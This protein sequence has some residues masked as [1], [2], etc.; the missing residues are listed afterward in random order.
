M[1]YKKP[2]V[3]IIML[4]LMI[5]CFDLA[6][7]YRNYARPE[8]E[9]ANIYIKNSSLT[10]TD[11]TNMHKEE[12]KETDKL[13]FTGWKQLDDES[14]SYPY[15]E[16]S[17]TVDILKVCGNSSLIVDAPMIFLG[18]TESCILDEDTAYSLFGSLEVSGQKITYNERELTVIA[19][20]NKLKDTII[21]HTENDS[22]ENMDAIAL[23]LN[24]EGARTI[25]KF[26]NRYAVSTNTTSTAVYSEVVESNIYYNIANIFTLIIP[27]SIIILLLFNF[28]KVVKKS[29]RKPILFLVYTIVGC[30][31]IGMFIALME[32]KPSIPYDLIPNKWSDFDYWTTL[33]KGYKEKYETILYMKKYNMDIV[34]IQSMFKSIVCSIISIILFF[35]VRKRFKINNYDNLFIFLFAIIIFE[36]IAVLIVRMKFGLQIS[37]LRAWLLIPYYYLGMY[38]ISFALKIRDKDI[39]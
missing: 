24:E 29:K 27:L 7:G 5:M 12:E 39:S 33:L 38:G 31:F 4:C 32:F 18:D 34:L 26:N 30:T 20:Q 28:I 6:L 8:K 3:N 19:V 21:M 14:I 16:R 13:S 9:I 36:F 11:I 17:A 35:N 15:L 10:A 25:K 37:E 2:V 1:N 23:E 22:E